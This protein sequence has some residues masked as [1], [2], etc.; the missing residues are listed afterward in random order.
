MCGP[1]I[2]SFRESKVLLK[3]GG[4]FGQ[5]EYMNI[6]FNVGRCGTMPASISISSLLHRYNVQ[7]HSAGTVHILLILI[8]IGLQIDM[9]L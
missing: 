6:E 9:F 2:R 7:L 5:G 4:S 3:I 1:Y 8:I